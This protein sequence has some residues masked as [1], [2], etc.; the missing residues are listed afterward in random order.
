M[1]KC[2]LKLLALVISCYA[3][4]GFTSCSDNEVYDDSELRQAIGDLQ[5]RVEALEAVKNAMANKLLV[6][7]VTTVGSGYVI[8]FSDGSKV[9]IENK[10]IPE[11]KE[12]YIRDIIVSESNV[13]FYLSDD[14]IFSIPLSIP[15]DIEFGETGDI[16]MMAGQTRSISY[17]VISETDDV[18]IEA[19]SSA[20]IK[21]RV[22]A[23]SDNNKTGR[24][25][26]SVLNETDQFSKVVVIAN[27]GKRIVMRKL[28]FTNEGIGV[29][30]NTQKVAEP[31]ASE[32]EL[33][34]VTS[35]PFE[36]VIPADAQSWISPVTGRGLEREIISL[37]LKP[38]YGAIR[39]ANV[40]V[41]STVSHMKVVFNVTQRQE[42]GA[43]EKLALIELLAAAGIKVDASVPIQ[44]FPGVTVDPISGNVSEI[45]L[46]ELKG[47]LPRSISSFPE[48]RKLRIDI[49]HITRIPDEI[50]ALTKLEELY[51]RAPFGGQEY[52]E[53]A[54]PEVVGKLKSLKKLHLGCHR[55]SALSSNFTNLEKLESLNLEFNRFGGETLDTIFRLRNLR[56]IDFYQN[57]LSGKIPSSISN[58][59]KLESLNLCINKLTGNIPNELYALSSLKLLRLMINDM[60]GVLSPNICNLVNLETLDLSDNK[61]YGSIPENIGNLKKLRSLSL[62]GNSMSGSLPPSM[63]NLRQ[64]ETLSVINNKFSGTIP[65][66][67]GNISTLSYLN[68]AINEFS[69]S[70]P[71]S[72]APVETLW[73]YGNKLTGAIPEEIMKRS[74][75]CNRWGRIV[76]DNDIDVSTLRFKGPDEL[77]MY[78]DTAHTKR[79]DISQEYS[80]HNLVIIFQWTSSCSYFSEA[81]SLVKSVYAKYK[82]RGLEVVGRTFSECSES[83]ASNGMTWPTYYS[84]QLD[85]PYYVAPTITVVDKNRDVIFTDQIQDRATLPDVVEAYFA[86]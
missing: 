79:Y 9:T 32:I 26:I 52:I 48:L 27:N 14:S 50:A 47:E 28:T 58:L 64:L 1:K 78:Y 15:I 46:M 74:D 68:L 60:S 73:L 53:G 6:D 83:I 34:F 81:L 57:N 70:I 71:A 25:E 24:L 5:K 80:K 8:T 65:P 39:S 33:E 59:T 36:V 41:Q 43:D 30:D 20:D 11:A 55:M 54:M 19:L 44:N 13:T 10:E 38:N 86:N 12:C 29:Y 31:D 61:F 40:T 23:D 42:K 37:E 85:Y 56:E 7:D 49:A 2:F 3:V 63:A 16:V 4:A 82:D 84:P 35:E 18:E 21:V 51:L 66:E 22:I 45:E 17:S 72:L 77:D 76:M 62:E 75:W 69:G 67:L